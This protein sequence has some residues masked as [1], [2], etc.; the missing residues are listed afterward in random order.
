MGKRD[1]F[2]H[3]AMTTS[4]CSPS[5]FLP[6]ITLLPSPLLHV[7]KKLAKLRGDFICLGTRLNEIKG[8]GDRI[9]PEEIVI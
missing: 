2:D 8:N 1:M 6:L 5:Q 9:Y 7:I 4:E 3:Q